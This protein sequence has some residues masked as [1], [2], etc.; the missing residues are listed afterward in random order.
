MG[1]SLALMCA[2]F[3]SACEPLENVIRAV[4][5]DDPVAKMQDAAYITYIQPATQ[6]PPAAV[7]PEPVYVPPPLGCEP[8]RQWRYY[9]YDCMDRQ[10]EP[11][12]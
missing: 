2:A 11:Y 3:T 4:N 12:E 8:R 5:P 7:E 10:M 1:L 9:W 6:E